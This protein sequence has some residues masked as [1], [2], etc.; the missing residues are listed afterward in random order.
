VGVF[1]ANML[2]I[3]RLSSLQS[4]GVRT[5][6]DFDG[7]FPLN[8]EETAL[9]DRAKGRI[10]LFHLDGPMIFG[11]ARAISQEHTAMQDHDV[12][13]VDLQDVPHLGVTAALA[14]ENAIQDAADAGRQVFLVGAK[15]KTLKRLEKLGVLR[16]VPA[17]HLAETRAEALKASLKA[18]AA[19]DGIDY[20]GDTAGSE[21]PRLA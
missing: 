13:I 6:T 9:M 15:G 17:E 7:E 18:L 19:I 5:I 3:D 16:F 10:L 21:V 8:A 11:V 1:I 2:T 20:S 14:L 4:E 12:L